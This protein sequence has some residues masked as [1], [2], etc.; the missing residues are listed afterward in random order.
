MATAIVVQLISLAAVAALPGGSEPF[1]FDDIVTAVRSQTPVE[2]EGQ[3]LRVRIA[4]S[5]PGWERYNIRE[6]RARSTL[7]RL[8]AVPPADVQVQDQLPIP[9]GQW[10]MSFEP[11]AVADAASPVQP[12]ERGGNAMVEDFASAV[13]LGDGRW[14]I[15]DAPE[16]WPGPGT[17]LLLWLAANLLFLVP[18][19]WLFTRRLVAPIRAF[20]ETA[21]RAGRGDREAV[22]AQSGPREIRTAAGALAEMQRRIS[23]AVDERTKLIAA[24]AHDLRTPL[25]RLRFRAEYA[26]REHRDR[27]VQDVERMDAMIG[28]VLAFARGEE[29]LNRQRLDLATLVQS[30]ADDLLETGADVTVA[31][32]ASVEVMG[33]PLALRRLVANLLDN[34]VKYGGSARCLVRAEGG[35]ALLLVEDDGPGIAEE[36]LERMFTPFER[37][38]AARDPSTGGV[39]LG[40]ALARGIARAHG[41]DVWLSRLPAQGLR[42][43]VRLPACAGRS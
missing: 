25:T 42:A 40:L 5:P 24:V 10:L 38:D 8:L 19:A 6:A 39:G 26:P 27:I 2:R 23:T 36:S 28:G 43:H 31:E 37:G 15:V 3:T 32:A 34:A 20:A 16:S 4:D 13:R 35:D 22:F 41:G 9:G 30:V 21:E 7:A 14:A 29:R 17:F 11:R 1:T 12:F 33:D 18:L